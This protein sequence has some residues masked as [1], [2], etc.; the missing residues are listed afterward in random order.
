MQSQRN[1][2]SEFDQQYENDISSAINNNLEEI[3][4]TLDSNDSSLVKSRYVTQ[5]QFISTSQ[6]VGK[7]DLNFLYKQNFEQLSIFLVSQKLGLRM[8][9][10][11][12]IHCFGRSFSWQRIQLV[13]HLCSK[14]I[15]EEE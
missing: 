4:Y 2:S 1:V 12:C 14:L 3:E 10:I 7:D 13:F 6:S 11:L 5:N 8:I 9:G 15:Q